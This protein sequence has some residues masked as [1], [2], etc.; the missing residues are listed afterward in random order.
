MITVVAHCIVKKGYKADFIAAV[1]DMIAESRN[2]KGN[3]SYTLMEDIENEDAVAF[4]QEWED[5]DAIEEHGNQ[6]HFQEGIRIIRELIE[7][8]DIIR[9]QAV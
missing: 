6:L 2:E 7:N 4:I 3:V 5:V 1:Q 8:M 9:Y